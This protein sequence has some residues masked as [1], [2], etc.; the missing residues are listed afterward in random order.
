MYELWENFN[1]LSATLSK[2]SVSMIP[3]ILQLTGAILTLITALL[4]SLDI[5]ENARRGIR[6]NLLWSPNFKN[7]EHVESP[8]SKYNDLR[9]SI[10]ELSYGMAGIFL[11]ILGYIAAVI[12]LD[13]KDNFFFYLLAPIIVLLFSILVAIYWKD[14]VSIVSSTLC[15][16]LII[17]LIYVSKWFAVI[18]AFLGSTTLLMLIVI[19]FL[20][21]RIINR[22]IDSISKEEKL[23]RLLNYK[24]PYDSVK[25]LLDD[26]E[27]RGMGEK[28]VEITK[29]PITNKVSIEIKIK[30]DSATTQENTDETS[31]TEKKDKT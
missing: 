25:N 9:T 27:D 24:G 10:R 7:E 15:L 1:Q 20:E 21:S 28:H 11:I 2:M 18:A 5:F 23:I 13:Y 3:N 6:N 4:A 17:Y 29:D 19:S 16:L 26:L 14:I 31:N 12:G 22:T 8:K 30:K